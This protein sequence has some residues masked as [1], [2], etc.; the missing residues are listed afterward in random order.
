MFVVG[1]RHYRA[2]SGSDTVG[3]HSWTALLRFNDVPVGYDNLYYY[4]SSMF[5]IG[6]KRYQASS[7]LDK[8]HIW[9]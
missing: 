7:G 5:V 6:A 2:R 8:V 3:R 1:A 9:C 4:C